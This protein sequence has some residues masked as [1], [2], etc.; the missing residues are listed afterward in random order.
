MLFKNPMH[1]IHQ[2]DLRESKYYIHI[3]SQVYFA[4]FGLDII[5]KRSESI[6]E[7]Q[8]FNE[9]YLAFCDL[10]GVSPAQFLGKTN[11]EQSTLIQGI[12]PK[13]ITGK[14]ICSFE[15]KDVQFGHVKGQIKYLKISVLKRCIDPKTKKN[16][17]SESIQKLHLTVANGIG[18]VDYGVELVYAKL[19]VKN[20]VV[21][22]LSAINQ[23]EIAQRNSLNFVDLPFEVNAEIQKEFPQLIGVYYPF[24]AEDFSDLLYNLSEKT[25][26]ESTFE[27]YSFFKVQKGSDI[28]TLVSVL[29][30][31]YKLA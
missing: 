23:K 14:V 31:S 17:H 3:D 21:G 15:S 5:V 9:E 16:L 30:D 2:N 29:I 13:G 6:D 4:Q 28:V 22:S 1:K 7:S 11:D 19:E 26:P 18:F 10:L 25:G 20:K 12:L 24:E 8:G 27:Y